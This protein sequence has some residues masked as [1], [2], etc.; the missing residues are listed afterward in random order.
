MFRDK[1]REKQRKKNLQAKKDGQQQEAKTP[2]TK[3]KTRNTVTVMKK[4]TAKQRRAVQS[5]VD[6][7]DLTRDY[8]LWKKVKKGE[9]SESEY[10][11]LTGTEDLL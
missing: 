6:D 2:K 10:A 8:R 7:E 3:D 1:N 9:I 5:A 11:K 4:R